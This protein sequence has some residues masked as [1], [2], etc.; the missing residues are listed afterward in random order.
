M[1]AFKKYPVFSFIFLFATVCFLVPAR[2]YSQASVVDGRAPDFKG[3]EA[4]LYSFSDLITYTQ[5]KESIDTVDSKGVFEL[6]AMVDRPQAFKVKIGNQS[7]KLYML[8]AYKYGVTFPAPDPVDSGFYQNP[9]A[10]Q[11]TDLI[12]YGDST[13]LN[14]R[15]IDF[16]TQF[17]RFWN[18]NYKYFVAKKLHHKLDSFELKMQKRYEKVNSSYLRTY[19][20]Y[21]IALINDNTGRH[22]AYIANKYILYKP[23]HYNNF[24]YMEFFNQFFKLYLEQQSIGKFG[25]DILNNI[26]QQPN[27]PALNAV[28]KNDSW[29][30]TSDSLREL[31]I[32]KGLYELYYVPKFS[33]QNI[34]ALVDQIR[35]ITKNPEHKKIA[36]NMLHLFN[37]LQNGVEAPAFSLKDAKENTFQLKSFKGKYIYLDFF[38]PKSVQSQQEM[39]KMEQIK[40]KYGDKVLFISVCMEGEEEEF[41]EFVKKN[42]KYNWLILY[43]AKDKQMLDTYLVKAPATYYLINQEGYLV[44]SPATRPSEGIEFKFKE[45]FRTRRK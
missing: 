23:I 27:Y 40:N 22:R 10:E 13:E 31:V 3:Q 32:L 7:A 8:K 26:N 38:S 14:A 5:V 33:K 37:N 20:T 36:D 42:P 24:E 44:Q 39:K 16:N 29:L 12:I 9:N 30:A 25:N 4:S 35:S 18:K 2:V 1:P 17:E 34:I 11:S 43:G 6:S 28:L 21:N 15:I 45:M 41:R 19:V